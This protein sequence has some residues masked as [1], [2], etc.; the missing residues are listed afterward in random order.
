MTPAALEHSR[1]TSTRA[2]KLVD[3]LVGVQT[4]RRPVQRSQNITFSS[5]SRNIHSL[6]DSEGSRGSYRAEKRLNRLQVGPRRS[7]RPVD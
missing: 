5:D 4:A 1:A 2:E 6:V 7:G 3:G